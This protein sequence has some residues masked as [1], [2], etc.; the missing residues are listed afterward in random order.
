MADFLEEGVGINAIIIKAFD[1]VPHDWQLTKPEA[2]GVVSS[3][4]ICVRE[5][6][7]GRKQRVRV[8]G[9][10]SK[11]VKVTSCVPQGSTLGPLQFTVYVNDIW[12]NADSS[13]RLFAD[14]CIIYGKITNKNNI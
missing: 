11:E 13:I 9:Q 6:I 14:D 5:F 1:S 7:V 8:G 12:R 10:L 3:V 2:S 4:V